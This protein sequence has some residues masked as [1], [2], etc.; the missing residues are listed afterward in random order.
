MAAKPL[1]Y[2]HGAGPQQPV[3]AFKHE[4]DMILFGRDM[5]TTKVAYY[6]DVRW[7]PAGAGPTAAP[8]RAGK[9]RRV[10]AIRGSMAPQVSPTEAADAIVSA[11]L[12][13]PRPRGAAA[14]G[15]PTTGVAGR[16][17]RRPAAGRAALP[18]RRPGREPIGG[19]TGR[20]SPWA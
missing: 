8:N 16:C 10:A 6:S 12:T 15:R 4:A 1:L 3:A 7:P 20:P 9:T 2:V 11:T 13:A 14:A 5:S 18:A 17:R 19:P